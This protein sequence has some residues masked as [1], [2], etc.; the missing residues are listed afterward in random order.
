M[1]RGSIPGYYYDEEKKKYFKIQ[2]NHVAPAD[3]K[4]SKSNV[5]LEKRAA[6]KRKTEDRSRATRFKQ[7][8]RPSRVFEHP[9]SG[10]V[11]LGRELGLREHVVDMNV[12]DTFL[13]SQL[14]PSRAEIAAPN[15]ASRFGT[16]FDAITV[17]GRSVL[18]Y[19]H[20]GASSV[21]VTQPNPAHRALF[22]LVAFNSPLVN[23]HTIAGSESTTLIAC[24]QEPKPPGN[25]FIGAFPG[26]HSATQDVFLRVGGL[27]SSLWAS[28]L[29]GETCHLAV[30]GSEA[31]FILDIASATSTYRL[32]L[33]DESRDITWLDTRT[34]AFGEGRK[35]ALFDTRSGG[36]S[37]RFQR[38]LPIT[39]IDSPDE[40]GMHLLVA[41]NRRSDM[42]DTRMD[43][44]PLL[45]F[46]HVHQGPQLQ[47]A[48]NIAG[49]GLIA[50]LDVN[51]DIQTY[52]LRSARPVGVLQRPSAKG[53]SLMTKLRWTELDGSAP[54]LQACQD[55]SVVKWTYGGAEDDEASPSANKHR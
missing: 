24:T 29:N 47:L 4:Y 32:P 18:A 38:K 34:V 31:V 42:Y 30:S 27:E 20:A 50:A 49:S 9:L 35:V 54:A 43:K 52:S 37:T 33:Q 16:L 25:V 22:P 28:S 45:G 40:S 39:A 2:A 21:Y 15:A 53:K 23:I 7:T 19:N 17:D 6:K 44:A 5:N 12:R 1:D 41:D 46:S 14:R 10:G 11:G 48:A 3:A 51:N 26:Q 36:K 55:G 13:V 8:V